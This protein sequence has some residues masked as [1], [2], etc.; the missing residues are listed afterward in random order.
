MVH[1]TKPIAVAVQEPR[2]SHIFLVEALL[3]MLEIFFSSQ[4]PLA[5][6]KKISCGTA[7]L[8]KNLNPP[9]NSIIRINFSINPSRWQGRFKGYPGF[10]FKL[11]LDGSVRHFFPDVSYNQWHNGAHDRPGKPTGQ[12]QKRVL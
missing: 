3:S 10:G 7:V 9:I 6:Q 12:R 5:V 11:M 8:A 2:N 1:E 4:W